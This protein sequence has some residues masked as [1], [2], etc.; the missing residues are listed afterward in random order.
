MNP[1]RKWLV[2]RTIMWIGIVVYAVIIIRDHKRSDSVGAAMAE[3]AGFTVAPVTWVEFERPAGVPLPPA[4]A[5]NDVTVALGI[6]STLF[7][8]GCPAKGRTFRL[9]LGADGLSRFEADGPLDPCVVQRV[10]AASW[11]A[12]SPALE[13]E[14]GGNQ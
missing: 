8:T 4:V 13:L 3:V 10:W 6:F 9:S 11:P 12:I 2:L 5:G 14:L 7:D 1:D